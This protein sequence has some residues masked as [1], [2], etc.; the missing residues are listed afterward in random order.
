MA[1]NYSSV[2]VGPKREGL[3][4]MGFSREAFLNVNCTMVVTHY[5][6]LNQLRNQS[7]ARHNSTQS[8]FAR[9][10]G[11]VTPTPR[12]RYQP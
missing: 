2:D 10:F 12:V 3:F 7:L 5:V 1:L 6:D 11:G 4:E 8:C 9:L